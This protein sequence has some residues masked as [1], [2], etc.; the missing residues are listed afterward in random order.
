VN[1]DVCCDASSQV[2]D[3]TLASRPRTI[4]RL[5]LSAPIACASLNPSVRPGRTVKSP[6]ADRVPLFTLRPGWGSA[7]CTAC[8]SELRNAPKKGLKSTLP[9]PLRQ[10]GGSETG[11]CKPAGWRASLDLDAS[12]D[13]HL[14]GV[15][16]PLKGPRRV[17]E[18][19]E[20]EGWPSSRFVL[21][22]WSLPSLGGGRE[23]SQTSLRTAGRRRLLLD[24]SR[25]LVAWAGVE[26]D[27]C[28]ASPKR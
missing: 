14:N 1:A 2:V 21:H 19:V 20:H 25:V 13:G 17:G 15:G 4:P 16:R 11:G 9:F 6:A 5:R 28:R 24:A 27:L 26:S 12:P 18:G 8:D 3:Y 23:L 7:C 22:P 10:V